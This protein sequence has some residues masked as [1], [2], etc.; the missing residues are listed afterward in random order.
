MRDWSKTL[1]ASWVIV[2]SWIFRIGYSGCFGEVSGCGR[3]HAFS[4]NFLFCGI[5]RPSDKYNSRKGRFTELAALS[6]ASRTTLIHGHY[7]N[8]A[9]E[10]RSR[11]HVSDRPD[12][13]SPSFEPPSSHANRPLRQTRFTGPQPRL[14]STQ[15]ARRS[16]RRP[17][18]ESAGRASVRRSSVPTAKP[19]GLRQRR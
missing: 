5:Y 17:G 8:N 3:N 10:K 6:A 4:Q 1:S 14:R 2:Y 12:L 9:L 7:Q 11:T 18:S 15:P 13:A 19:P 16:A